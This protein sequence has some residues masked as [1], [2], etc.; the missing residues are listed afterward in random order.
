MTYLRVNPQGRGVFDEGF[1]D[2]GAPERVWSHH[3][4]LVLL[5]GV[6]ERSHVGPDGLYMNKEKDGQPSQARRHL[7]TVPLDIE[8]PYTLTLLGRREPLRWAFL[9][10]IWC[11]ALGALA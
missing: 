8:G 10:G 1:N 4:H 11:F 5:H 9:G 2:T 3:E 6:E 7:K